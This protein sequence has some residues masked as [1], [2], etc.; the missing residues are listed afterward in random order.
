[1]TVVKKTKVAV[2]SMWNVLTCKTCLGGDAIMLTSDRSAAGRLATEDVCWNAPAPGASRLERRMGIHSL[3]E[4]NVAV[5]VT[6]PVT[7]R[8]PVTLKK[9]V[10]SRQLCLGSYQLYVVLNL[11]RRFALAVNGR[12]GRVVFV[13]LGWNLDDWIDA[14]V[15]ERRTAWLDERKRRVLRNVVATTPDHGQ[16]PPALEETSTETILR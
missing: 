7:I 15:Q 1:M 4:T 5:T 10:V 9:T 14:L 16:L 6:V 12:V 13:G 8:V 2:R 11:W 3:V